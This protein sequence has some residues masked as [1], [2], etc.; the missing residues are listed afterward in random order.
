MVVESSESLSDED[1][2]P[3]R[4]RSPVKLVKQLVVAQN[5]KFPRMLP[6]GEHPGTVLGIESTSPILTDIVRP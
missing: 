1:N 6:C 2:D 4:S 5:K 3:T